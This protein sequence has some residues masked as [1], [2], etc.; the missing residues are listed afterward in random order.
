[1]KNWTLEQVERLNRLQRAEL[2]GVAPCKGI[3]TPVRT[4]ACLP[5]TIMATIKAAFWPPRAAGSV[6]IAAIRRTG[7]TSH[8]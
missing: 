7:F 5:I 1:M 4:G 3:R 8:H 6:R 2:Y